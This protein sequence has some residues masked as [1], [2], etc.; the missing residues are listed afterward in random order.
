MAVEAKLHGTRRAL[1]PVRGWA[2]SRRTPDQQLFVR[3][4]AAYRLIARSATRLP[5]R[6]RL[7]RAMIDRAFR[8]A[9]ASTSRGDFD[10][11]LYGFA[12]DFEYRPS[13]GLMPPDLEP[14]FRGRDGYL[15][16][17]GYWRDAFG[18]IRWDPEEV[19]DFGNVFLVTAQQKGS[20]S[21]SGVAVAQKVFQLFT[22]RDGLVLRQEDF[23]D[24][25][26]A[27]RAAA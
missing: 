25:D 27:M 4:P 17:W 9:Y 20:G 7:R 10:V 3:V 11:V 22:L 23:V 21:G 12:D 16:L 13:S 2:A 5:Q 24:F 15:K 19:L 26:E 18:D 8:L 14:V 6:S 1:P